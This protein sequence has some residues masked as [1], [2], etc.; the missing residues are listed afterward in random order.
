MFKS[1]S[2]ATTALQIAIRV[3]ALI[4]QH[5]KLLEA[6]GN[7][8]TKVRKIYR[9]VTNVDSSSYASLPVYSKCISISLLIYNII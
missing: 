7:F 8:V 2:L 9:R 4:M 3:Y 5:D 6:T 1:L